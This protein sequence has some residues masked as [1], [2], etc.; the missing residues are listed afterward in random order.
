MN[1]KICLENDAE[2]IITFNTI[3]QKQFYLC[4]D[5]YKTLFNNIICCAQ[6]NKVIANIDLN[7][8][9]NI[10]ID[11]ICRSNFIYYVDCGEQILEN[12]FCYTPDNYKGYCYK[13]NP[14]FYKKN[15]S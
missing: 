6:C 3:N 2:Q 9:E 14:Q 13:P 15:N 5:C 8:K 7:K 1:C 4:E 11:A 10:F 12:K